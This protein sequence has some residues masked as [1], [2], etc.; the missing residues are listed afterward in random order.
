MVIGSDQQVGLHNP[1]GASIA[2]SL[3]CTVPWVRLGVLIVHQGNAIGMFDVV[4]EALLGLC[5][6]LDVAGVGTMLETGKI[7]AGFNEEVKAGFRSYSKLAALVC[8]MVK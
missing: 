4:L 8:M 6:E 1:P 2:C 5:M 3:P 7:H